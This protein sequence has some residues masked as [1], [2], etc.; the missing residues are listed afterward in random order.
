MTDIDFE[1]EAQTWLRECG[2]DSTGTNAVTLAAKLRD[3]AEREGQDGYTRGQSDGYRRGVEAAI[4]IGD[5]LLNMGPITGAVG[6][7]AYY[8]VGKYVRRLQALLAPEPAKT[9]ET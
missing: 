9:E 5:L 4:Q 2:Y 8:A 1:A 7:A 6:S 3:I